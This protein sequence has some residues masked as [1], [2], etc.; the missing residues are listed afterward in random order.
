M[1]AHLTPDQLRE[2]PVTPY[3][4]VRAQI[5]PGALFFAAGTYAISRLIQQFTNS[6]WS[7]VGILFWS[8]SLDRVLLLESVEDTGVR[9]AP[10]SKYLDDY[11]DDQPYR[12]SLVIAQADGV[13]E[14]LERQVAA[15]GVDQLTRPYDKE[16]IAEIALRIALKIGRKP[17]SGR[18]FICSELVQACFASAGYVFPLGPGGFISPEDIWTDKRVA[19]KWRI[20]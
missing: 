9:F 16:E 2:L 12:G 20:Q 6:P 17:D 7:H 19:L 3:A 11:E 18:K 5:P 8:K 1:A 13:D 4:Q 15:F 10:V 14:A